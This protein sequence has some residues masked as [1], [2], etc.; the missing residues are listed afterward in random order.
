MH[1]DLQ[2]PKIM[3]ASCQPA[4]HNNHTVHPFLVPISILHLPTHPQSLV[5][6]GTGSPKLL[7]LRMYRLPCWRYSAPVP[8]TDYKDFA[9]GSYDSLPHMQKTAR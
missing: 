4:T 7:T 3:P 9:V 1:A 5:F 6:N 2:Q 8:A